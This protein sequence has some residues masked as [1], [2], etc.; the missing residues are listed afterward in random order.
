MKNEPV[1]LKLRD[2]LPEEAKG[3]LWLK[4]EVREH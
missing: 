4:E 1:F 2:L 3:Q